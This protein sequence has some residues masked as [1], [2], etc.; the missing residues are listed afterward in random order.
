MKANQLS[1]LLLPTISLLGCS[2]DAV[3][4]TPLEPSRD[5][6]IQTLAIAACDRYGDT[7]AGC[8]GYGSGKKYATTADCQ[9]DF[10]KVAADLWPDAQ[11]SNGRIDSSAY[12]QCEDRAKTF[13]CSTGMQNAFDAVAAL[14]ECKASKVCSDSAK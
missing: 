9:R 7:D 10:E 11:C 1:L 6:R 5:T 4:D 14:E 12:Q 3:D 13:A 8:P 2:S